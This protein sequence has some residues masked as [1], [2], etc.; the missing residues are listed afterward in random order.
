MDVGSEEEDEIESQTMGF[1]DDNEEEDSNG[2]EKFN[3]SNLRPNGAD[4]QPRV[5]CHKN[6]E[7]SNSLSYDGSGLGSS[8]GLASVQRSLSYHPQP[9]QF[10][11]SIPSSLTAVGSPNAHLSATLSPA[12]ATG[13]H[14]SA[15]NG[16]VKKACDQEIIISPVAATST[17]ASTLTSGSLDNNLEVDEDY[18]A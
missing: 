17:A 1:E 16:D 6:M 5:P 15:R 12:M 10:T 13:A 14:Y 2:L 4:Y 7:R 18:D 11:I 3:S 9:P 8:E